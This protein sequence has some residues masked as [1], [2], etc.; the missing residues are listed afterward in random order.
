MDLKFEFLCTL[1]V[2]LGEAQV[3][4]EG[5]HGVRRIVPLIGGK[6]EGPKIKGEVLPFGADWVLVRPDGVFQ[7]DVRATI[8]TDDDELIYVGYKGI[9]DSSRDYFRVTPFFETS[10]EKYSWLNKIISVGIG[11]PGEGKVEYEIYQIL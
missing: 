5:P 6:I 7:L 9:F 4:G 3:I 10:S 8:R 1:L 11:K 2:E